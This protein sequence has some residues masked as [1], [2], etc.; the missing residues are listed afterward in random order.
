MAFMLRKAR[1]NAAALAA[2]IILRENNRQTCFFAE[3]DDRS[4]I[5]AKLAV[6][7]RHSL[8]IGECKLRRRTES[9]T[10]VAKFLDELK[11]SS[12]WGA[13]YY[14]TVVHNCG[15]EKAFFNLARRANENV[16]RV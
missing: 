12:D 7:G 15:V 10:C 13:S 9:R 3:D 14:I 6:S 1:A 5:L 4:E 16:Y 8:V 11:S 2:Q